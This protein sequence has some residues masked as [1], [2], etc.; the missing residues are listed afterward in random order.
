MRIGVVAGAQRW[1]RELQTSRG[2]C[3]D[4]S[5]PAW[6]LAATSFYL[7]PGCLSLKAGA[8]PD[9]LPSCHPNSHQEGLTVFLR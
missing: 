1:A 4:P 8:I 2:D 7:L 3:L 5:T 9:P 6:T